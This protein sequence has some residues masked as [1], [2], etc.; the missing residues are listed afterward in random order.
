MKG[1]ES[2]FSL[3][4]ELVHLRTETFQNMTRMRI[5][6]VLVNDEILELPV[7]MTQ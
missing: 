2:D 3:F 5:S 6:Q 7:N 4:S 1:Y